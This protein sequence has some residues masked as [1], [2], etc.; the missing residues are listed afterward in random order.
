VI[1][2]FYVL[3]G[4]FGGLTYG[5]SLRDSVVNSIQTPWLQQAANL[6]LALHCLLTVTLYMNPLNQQVEDWCK[7]PH[8]LV[9]IIRV[10][11]KIVY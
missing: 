8:G 10:L 5:N 11:N 2:L 6:M 7:C 9:H 1:T 3:A 4:G